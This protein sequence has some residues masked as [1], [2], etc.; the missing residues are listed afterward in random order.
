MLRVLVHMCESLC[1]CVCVHHGSVFS[2]RDGSSPGNQF[3]L[4]LCAGERS[5]Q[6]RPVPFGS[7]AQST[8]GPGISSVHE[9]HHHKH[10]PDTKTLP[11]LF[12]FFLMVTHGFGDCTEERN[13]RASF[14]F[15][16]L[17]SSETLTPSFF[18]SS[19]TR[20]NRLSAVLRHGDDVSG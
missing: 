3:S 19:C 14:S 1:V 11:F 15:K 2:L 8:A 16:T 13:K 6:F 17:N 9:C 10:N 18:G 7:T 20:K 5:K 12:F 4:S